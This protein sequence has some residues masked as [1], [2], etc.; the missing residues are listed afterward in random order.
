MNKENKNEYFHRSGITNKEI[1]AM[2]ESTHSGILSEVKD[3]A[4][5]YARQ[6][7]PDPR[8]DVLNVYTNDTTAK[9]QALKTD[10]GKQLQVETAESEAQALSEETARKIKQI[11]EE[12][13]Q[14]EKELHNF[15]L[16]LADQGLEP[17]D[18]NAIK[19]K[20][21]ADWIIIAINCGE[22]LLTTTA[23]QLIGGN[24]IFSFILAVA[25][26]AG[27]FLLAKQ[28]AIYLKEDSG[29]AKAKRIAVIATSIVALA[30]FYFLAKLRAESLKDSEHYAISPLLLV[31]VNI[32]FYL[33]TVIHYYKNSLT[34]KEKKEIERIQ[35]LKEKYLA[36]TGL[37]KKCEE[38]DKALS[39]ETSQKL[40][41][42]SQKENYYN[43]LIQKVDKC[44]MVA[45]HEFVSH[46]LLYRSDKKTPDCFIKIINSKK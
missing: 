12:K 40:N 2:L 44:N 16:D 46:N 17:E 42:L 4:R 3:R 26:T 13:K 34:P 35:R 30:V 5:L 9:Y 23:L 10:I 37:I 20:R 15:L 39:E 14:A 6:N 45:V 36:L 28:L 43:W 24:L 25:I 7:R 32:L 11:S 8:G 29:D 19:P 27:L 18:L 41:I 33:V 31:G 22:V 38:D 1:E 21:N